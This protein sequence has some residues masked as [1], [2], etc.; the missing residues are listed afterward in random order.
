MRQYRKKYERRYGVKW[1]YQNSKNV[2]RYYAFKRKRQGVQ[3]NPMYTGIGKGAPRLLNLE[4][5]FYVSESNRSRDGSTDAFTGMR[6]VFSVDGMG[7]PLSH[8][9]RTIRGTNRNIFSAAGFSSNI[10]HM[11]SSTVRNVDSSNLHPANS[12]NQM[13]IIDNSVEMRSVSRDV[14]A[15]GLSPRGR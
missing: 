2:Q 4:Q 12:T 11:N 10:H 13:Q 15:A 6:R 9:P 5:S 1:E 14:T 3:I 8:T 7:S